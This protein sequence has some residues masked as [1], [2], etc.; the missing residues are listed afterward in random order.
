MKVKVT[1]DRIEKDT[2]VLLIR[3]EENKKVDCPLAFLPEDTIEGDILD[4]EINRDEKTKENSKK[5]V[6]NLINKLKNKGKE[7]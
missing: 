1:V 5:R 6:E 3:P 7:D 4:I 2:A